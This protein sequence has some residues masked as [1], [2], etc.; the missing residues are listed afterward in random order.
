MPSGNLRTVSRIHAGVIAV[1][2]LGAAGLAAAAVWGAG[3]QGGSCPQYTPPGW[4]VGVVVGLGVVVLAVVLVGSLSV[5]DSEILQRVY[6]SVGLIEA[7]AA[8]AL[9]F[10]LLMKTPAVYSCG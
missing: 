4:V 5:E 3:V 9:I 1:L 8:G 6:V 7:A 10:N 2:V